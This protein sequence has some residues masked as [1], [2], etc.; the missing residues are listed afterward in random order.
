MQTKD[1]LCINAIR[2]L[3]SDAIDK[4]NSGHPGIVLDAAPMGYT[5]FA[6]SM[7]H[8]PSCP[9]WQNRDRFILSAG[10]GSMLLYALLHLFGYDLPLDE[11]KQFRQMGSITPGHPEYGLTEGV[12]ATTGPL[13]QG[14]A[15]AVGFAMA[16]AH[17]AATYNRP[18]FAVSDHYTF[19]LCGD[20]CLEEGISYEACSLAGTMKL[21]KL[22]LLYDRNRITIEGDIAAAFTEDVAGRFRAFDWHVVDGVDGDDIDA[23]GQAITQCKQSDKPSLVIVDTKIARY[24]PLEGSEESHGSPLGADNTA[25]LRKNLDWPLEEAFA[26]PDE[27]YETCRLSVAEGKKKRL[28]WEA[29]MEKYQQAFPK[30]SAAYKEALEKG[31]PGGV[32]QQALMATAKA[33]ATR[34]ASG[35]VLNALKDMVPGL[36]GGSAD[37]APSN[38]TILKGEAFFGPDSYEGRNMHFGIREF[39]MAAISNGLSLHGGIR[40]YCA[41]FLVFSDYMRAAIRLGAIMHQSVIYVL[42]H[43]S[44]GVGE[45]GAT[46]EP[47]EHLASLRAMPNCRVF[48][49]G[50]AKETVAAYLSA[51][52]FEGPTVLALSRQ[53]LPLLDGSG[54]DAMR[55]A[56][57]LS[58][59]DGEPELILIGTGSEVSLCEEAAAALRAKDVRVRVVSMPCMEL[60]YE[61][62]DAY[63]ESVLPKASKKRVAVE[64]ASSL[65]WHRVAGDCGA[66]ICLDHF[67]ASAPGPDLFKAYGFTVDNVVDTAQRLLDE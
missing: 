17:L 19:A 31:L 22:I 27:V 5:L 41:T 28:Q 62:D 37:L 9:N 49:P 48:R 54:L 7:A 55:G 20:G 29:M 58:D 59:S 16:Q 61:Q 26:I 50:D 12:E 10:H 56:Y 8:D 51:L 35:A 60:F 32:D 24:S 13:G 15:M 38:R 11:I 53:N 63:R 40:P 67:G 33:G 21:N 18:G 45:D 6:K 64:A 65:G 52:S 23:I 46:H 25:V 57:V 39:A 1:Q 44:I 36:F 4:A 43:D 47:I 66:C 30:L 34:N 2:I 42:T 3:G 14:I